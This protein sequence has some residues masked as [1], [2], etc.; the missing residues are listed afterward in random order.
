MA[1]QRISYVPL[2]K[3]DDI[4]RKE[5]ERCQREGS[6]RPERSAC[7]AHVPG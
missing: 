2:D 5:M 3:M 4:I 1:R 6:P 7:R